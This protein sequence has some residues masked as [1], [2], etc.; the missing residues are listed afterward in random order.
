MRLRRASVITA[1]LSV[2]I[3]IT[4]GGSVPVANAAATTLGSSGSPALVSS[5]GS[6]TNTSGTTQ[7]SLTLTLGSPVAQ[8]DTVVVGI[9]AQG[10]VSVSSVSDSRGNTYHVDVV[11]TYTS[12]STVKST[13]A[14]VTAPV[15]TALQ[16]GDAITV[17]LSVGNAWGFVAQDWSGITGLDQSGTM[18]SGGVASTAVSASTSG[19]TA[20]APEVVFA[21]ATTNGWPSITAGSGY[22]ATATLQASSGT[23]KREL[24]L[25]YQVVP[26]TG[27]QTGTFTLGS[28]GYWVAAVA[29][30]A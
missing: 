24:G 23:V 1:V 9:G 29:T 12:S 10:N 5:L 20:T 18:D 3:S 19:A 13:T 22:T 27:T 30:Y 14:L 11:R 8:G 2:V 17:T 15:T 4:G 6:I 7:D 26:S 21:L 25:E 16:A 28:N